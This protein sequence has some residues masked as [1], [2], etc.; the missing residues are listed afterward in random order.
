[1]AKYLAVVVKELE[2]HG[3]IIDWFPSFRQAQEFVD[4]QKEGTYR[5]YVKVFDDGGDY[6]VRG[7]RE[8]LER[9]WRQ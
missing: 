6:Y 8:E 9:I 7:S 2:D 1:M 5:I 3:E 4:A